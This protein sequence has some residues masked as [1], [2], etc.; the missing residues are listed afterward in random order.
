M[1]AVGIKH[2]Q[3]QEQ[4][5]NAADHP[6]KSERRSTHGYAVTM[7]YNTHR[8]K[9]RQSLIKLQANLPAFL[10]P[11]SFAVAQHQSS[12]DEAIQLGTVVCVAVSEWGNERF[13]VPASGYKFLNRVA[14]GMSAA[15]QTDHI[16]LFDRCKKSKVSVQLMS[17]NS[18]ATWNKSAEFV[19]GGRAVFQIFFQKR[20]HGC[21]AQKL[22]F[23]PGIFAKL[24]ALRSSRRSK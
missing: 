10:T 20:Q 12:L 3:P 9:Q 18:P 7:N 14:I 2:S 4:V 22:P 15:M 19:F 5:C 16:H 11:P 21:F 6:P 1:V 17:A 24:S 8:K 13:R 23:P